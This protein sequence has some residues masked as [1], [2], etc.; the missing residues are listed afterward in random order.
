[1]G[2]LLL[3]WIILVI[4]VCIVAAIILWAVSRFFPDVYPPARYIVGGVAL[5]IILVA[6]KP[7]L[8]AVL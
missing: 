6:L 2:G 4:V 1:M 8:S 7:I 3:D 5:I